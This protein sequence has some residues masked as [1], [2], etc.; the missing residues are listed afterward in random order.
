M[1][2]VISIYIMN[3]LFQVLYISNLERFSR[4][5][6]MLTIF[7]NIRMLSKFCFISIQASSEMVTV[8]KLFAIYIVGS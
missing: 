3:I 7:L 8:L 1:F 6:Y 2:L 4:R 5:I